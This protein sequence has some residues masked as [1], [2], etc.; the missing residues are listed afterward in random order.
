M[1]Q[2][3]GSVLALLLSAS[4]QCACCSCVVVI[5]FAFFNISYFF[6]YGLDY[7]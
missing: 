4:F 7:R 1:N 2:T 6:I 5:E 3:V